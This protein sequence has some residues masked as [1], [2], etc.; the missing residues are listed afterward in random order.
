MRVG[1]Y[2]VLRQDVDDC[3]RGELVRVIHPNADE[4]GK[5]LAPHAY[6]TRDAVYCHGAS[7]YRCWVLTTGLCQVAIIGDG[8]LVV[9]DRTHCRHCQDRPG[10]DGL[11]RPCKTCRGSGFVLV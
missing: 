10:F 7:G 6:E 8:E 2:A 9:V 5:P 11:G 1:E 4:T 3:S